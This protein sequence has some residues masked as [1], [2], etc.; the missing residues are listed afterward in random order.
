MLE[1]GVRAP[2]S[3]RSRLLLRGGNGNGP[4][5][6]GTD[7][8]AGRDETDEGIAEP[9]VAYAELGAE[10]RTTEGAAGAAERGEHERIEIALRVVLDGRVAR[11]DGQVDVRVVSR[12]ELEAKRIGS[13]SGAVLDGEDEGVLLP[14][15][16]EIGVAPRVEVAASR[17]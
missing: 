5:V 2:G 8:G 4:S 12:D 7:E 6:A 11:D 9:L 17:K 14:A 10:L 3:F 16:V 1:N 13:G 15:H